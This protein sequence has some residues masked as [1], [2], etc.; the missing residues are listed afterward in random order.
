MGK[1]II[2]F[3]LAL[4][5]TFALAG[6]M[7]FGASFGYTDPET[8]VTAG[9]NFGSRPKAVKLPPPQKGLNK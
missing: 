1:R 3:L 4:L 9:V 6:C 8:G 5:A 2:T 7:T